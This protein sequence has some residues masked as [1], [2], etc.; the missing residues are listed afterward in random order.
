MAQEI[1]QRETVLLDQARRGDG[2]AF[3]ALVRRYLGRILA[4]SRRILRNSADAED[5]VQNALFK[6]FT[7]LRQFHEHALLSTWLTKIAINEALMKLRASAAEKQRFTSACNANTEEAIELP[8][9]QSSPEAECISRDLASKAMASV[10]PTLCESF[11]L[12]AVEGWTQK[13]VS[14]TKGITLQTVKT[15]IF[16]ARRKMKAHLSGKDRVVIGPSVRR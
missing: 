10:S 14:E 7:N 1:V 15:R 6:A 2:D 16:R 3:D 12:Y 5:N 11:V 8:S 9:R 4:T 13:E